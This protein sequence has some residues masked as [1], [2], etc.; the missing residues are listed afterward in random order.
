MAQ[1]VILMFFVPLFSEL[2]L[3]YSTRLIMDSRSLD[4]VVFPSTLISVS[5]AFSVA[6]HNIGIPFGKAR[7]P[8]PRK[9]IFSSPYWP[10]CVSLVS[11]VNDW[12]FMNTKH[13]FDCILLLRGSFGLRRI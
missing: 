12:T 9:F 13:G 7:H 3:L 8:N 6:C 4:L 1:V 10:G 5:H 11:I 2:T